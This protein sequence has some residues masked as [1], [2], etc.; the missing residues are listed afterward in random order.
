[1]YCNVLTHSFSLV[2][3]SVISA[4]TL[5]EILLMNDF[6]LAI[7]GAEYSIHPPLKGTQFQDCFEVV[8]EELCLFK[9]FDM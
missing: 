2:D 3:G 5:M 1:M 9:M 4:S 8:F 6:K 7:N